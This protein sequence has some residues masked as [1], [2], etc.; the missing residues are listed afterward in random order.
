MS[1]TDRTTQRIQCEMIRLELH[2]SGRLL[3][4]DELAELEEIEQILG[5]KVRGGA[6][7]AELEVWPGADMENVDALLSA[8]RKAGLQS[9]TCRSMR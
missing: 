8:L 2:P 5:S 9:I 6:Q 7:R 3:V 4:D 1:R